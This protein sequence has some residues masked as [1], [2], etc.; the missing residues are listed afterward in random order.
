MRTM[1]FFI[2]SLLPTIAHAQ[3]CS[4]LK[5]EGQC[6]A[7]AACI[8]IPYGYVNPDLTRG[9]PYCDSTKPDHLIRCQSFQLGSNDQWSCMYRAVP[10]TQRAICGETTRNS[11]TDR[12]SADAAKIACAPGRDFTLCEQ[13]FYRYLYDLMIKDIQEASH[14]I[15]TRKRQEKERKVAE[16]AAAKVLADALVRQHAISSLPSWQTVQPPKAQFLNKRGA[17]ELTPAEVFK[18]AAPSVYVVKAGDSL[19][20]IDAGKG[21]TGSAVAISTSVALTNCHI[22][23]GQPALFVHRAAER[24]KEHAP[25]IATVLKAD[26]STDRCFLSVEGLLDPISHVRKMDD[27]EIGERVY[28]IGNPRG[29]SNTLG[30][31]LVSG[32]R[33]MDG[34]TLVQTSAPISGGSS[35]GALVDAHGA[36]IGI[37]TFL[38]RDAQ[39]LNFAIAAE[40]FWR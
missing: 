13:K 16:E 20:A 15:Q 14:L 2:F 11:C 35:G 17:T 33:K 39:N 19:D 40:E 28:T 30:D 9:E 12:V 7:A 32:V 31:G 3:L 34:V 22:I 24:H 27:V 38:V 23:K 18:A 26:L 29:L 6:W 5:T 4:E 1:L 21:V 8:W 10:L 25:L 36:L 37:T